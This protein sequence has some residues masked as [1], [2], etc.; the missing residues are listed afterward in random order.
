MRFA[1]IAITGSTGIVGKCVVDVALEQGYNIV[2]IDRAPPSEPYPDKDRVEFRQ[3]DATNYEAIVEAMRG[4]DALIHLAA[5]P[6]PNLAPDHI[7][8]NK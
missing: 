2:C 3:A 6:N 8:H 7:T 5:L 4:C 1:K